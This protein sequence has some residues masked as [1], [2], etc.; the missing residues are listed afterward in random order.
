VPTLRDIVNALD[1]LDEDATIYTDG[2]S[3]AAQ[4]L[5]LDP[6]EASKAKDAGLRYFLEVALARDAVDVW[7]A[8]RAGAE[9]TVDDKLLAISYYAEHDAYLPRD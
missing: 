3:P 4:A 5:V 6:R 2:R 1:E 7:S 8:W 9:P